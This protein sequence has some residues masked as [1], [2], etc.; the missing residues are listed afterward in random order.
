MHKVLLAAAFLVLAVSPTMEPDT[1]PASWTQDGKGNAYLLYRS[2]KERTGRSLTA[3]SQGNSN[4]CVGCASAKA[5][6]ILHGRRFSAEWI[7]ATSRGNWAKG[8]GSWAGWA[9]WSAKNVG[10]L[11][12]SS[13]PIVGEDFRVYSPEKS[14]I[15]Q[16]R[17]PPEHLKQIAALYK[18]AG[19]YKL[20]S[21]DELRGAISNG[22]PV[23]IGSNVSFGPRRGQVKSRDGNLRRRWWGRWNHAMVFIGVDDRP[24]SNKGAL[25]MNSWGETWVKGPKRFKDEPNGCFWASK[26][27]VEKMVKQGDCYVIRPII[28]L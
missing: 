28:G 8:A 4:S 26:S 3:M 24:D 19:Y 10:V 21:Y 6:E 18:S 27:A 20:K 15:Y 13:Y 2:Y 23:I 1:T 22:Y 17:G 14:N 25:L 7:Y 12:A 16:K 5:L 11:P 9:A